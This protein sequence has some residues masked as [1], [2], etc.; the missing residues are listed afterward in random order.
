[1]QNDYTGHYIPGVAK[2]QLNAGI[3]VNNATGQTFAITYQY[4]DPIWL[5]D[6]NSAKASPYQLIG[7]RMGSRIG[8]K[9]YA[10]GGT[11][12][13]LNVTYSLGNDINAA[14]NRYYNA[15]AGRNYYLGLRFSLPSPR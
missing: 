7:A 11:D 10:F 15:A 14:G 5:N 6:A 8:R 13:L 9:W 1:L 12:N 3:D 2:Q 4:S